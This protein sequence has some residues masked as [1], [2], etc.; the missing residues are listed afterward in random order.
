MPKLFG[1]DIAKELS[2]GM[3]SGLL[4]C[5]LIKVTSTTPDEDT[6]TEG[7]LKEQ[8]Y[9]C[10]GFLDDYRDGREPETVFQIGDRKVLI[11]GATLPKNIVPAVNDKVE[12][13]KKRFTIRLV[14]RDPAAA[15]YEC[16][17]RP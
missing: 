5:K 15:T 6:P 16:L 14:K 17:G 3:A 13:E 8:P 1:V 10:R 2:K 4:P 9:S 7:G 11:L 12:I